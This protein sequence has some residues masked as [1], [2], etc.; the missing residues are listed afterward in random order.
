[1]LPIHDLLREELETLVA[2]GLLWLDPAD[3]DL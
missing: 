3:Q 2:D 1:V